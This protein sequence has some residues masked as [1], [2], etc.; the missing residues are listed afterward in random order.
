MK[1]LVRIERVPIRQWGQRGEEIF[2][3]EVREGEFIHIEG[4]NGSG[5][6]H[7]LNLMAALITPSGGEVLL[8]GRR[9]SRMSSGERTRWR[10][11]IGLIPSEAHLLSGYTVIEN[12]RYSATLL[13]A[14]LKAASD[15]AK[16]SA[17]LCGLDSVSDVPVE[18]LSEGLRKRVVIARSLVNRPFLI[19]ADNPLEGLDEESQEEFLYLCTKLSQIGYSIVMTSSAPLPANIGALR[20]IQ[21]G[22]QQE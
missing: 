4:P 5:K 9:L 10:R 8:D 22:R 15:Y 3:C 1:Q 12:L 2:S 21:I 16:E 17:A 13:G 19:L 18:E 20:H 7:I 14:K 6:S 11:K